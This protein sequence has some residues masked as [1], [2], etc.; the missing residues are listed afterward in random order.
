[1]DR[2]YEQ[3]AAQILEQVLGGQVK[4]RDVPGAAPN[5]HD[6]D[7]HLPNGDIVAVEVTQVTN[8]EERAFWSPKHKKTWLASSLCK[9][10]ALDVDPA[11]YRHKDRSDIEGLL[12]EMERLGVEAFGLRRPVPAQAT[13]VPGGGVKSGP[14]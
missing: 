5:T 12:K 9:S 3:L 10:W 13:G 6:F 2:S 1:V 8:E 14:R 4:W 11:K 7:L